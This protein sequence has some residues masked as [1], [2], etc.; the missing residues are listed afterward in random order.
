M[1]N[2]QHVDILTRNGVRVWN[3]WRKEE[4]AI[5]PDLSEADLSGADLSDADLSDA[6]LMKANLSGANL[7]GADLTEAHLFDANLSRA[8]LTEA[9]L[10]DADLSGADLS[11]AS[12]FDADLS[13]ADLTEADFSEAYLNGANL[14]GTTCLKTTFSGATLTG[15]GV[16]GISVWDVNLDNAK[17]TDL[18][19]TARRD[20]PNIAVDNLEVAQFLYLLLN[21]EK[22]RHVIDTVTSKVVLILGRFSPE[23]KAVLDALREALRQHEPAYVP[24]LFDFEGSTERNFTETVTLLARMARFIIADITDPASIPQELQAIVP[25]VQVPVRPIIAQGAKPYAMFADY[26]LTPWMLDL[27]S[28]ANLE[29]LIAAVEDAIIVPAE[30]KIKE[31]RML[32]Q[33]DG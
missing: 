32:R 25:H 9:H 15:C 13:R 14:S 11:G 8:V 29:S 17:Q 20:E 18:R 22:I 24:V 26:R 3:L 5:H 12:L 6:N 21:N 1:A 7:S 19:I 33:V 30:A 23:R 16:Y 2:Q 28:Y 4:P 31:L 27:Y 10:F